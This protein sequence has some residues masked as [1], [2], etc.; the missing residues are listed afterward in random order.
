MATTARQA[1]KS[2]RC[3][4]STN[5]HQNYNTRTRTRTRT[6]ISCSARTSGE[7]GSSSKRSELKARATKSS[8]SLAGVLSI[9]CINLSRHFLALLLVGWA[10]KLEQFCGAQFCFGCFLNYHYATA[11]ALGPLRCLRPAQCH[12][13]CERHWRPLAAVAALASLGAF[14]VAFWARNRLQQTAT[15][16][17][18]TTTSRLLLPILASARHKQRIGSILK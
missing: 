16:T 5:E 11:A 12:C 6:R 2:V 3:D 7:K 13:H 9:E 18:T 8:L 10:A 4:G 15:A 14:L 1:Q 17:I